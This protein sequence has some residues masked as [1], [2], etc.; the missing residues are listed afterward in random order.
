[1]IS[2]RGFFGLAAAA[3]LAVLAAPKAA[4]KPS[5]LSVAEY[6][7][8]EWHEAFA[9]SASPDLILVDDI[10]YR[11]YKSILA[12]GE[13]RS[14]QTRSLRRMAREGPP[15]VQRRAY[16]KLRDLKKPPT[17][18]LQSSGNVDAVSAPF[19]DRRFIVHDCRPQYFQFSALQNPLEW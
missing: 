9:L 12:K 19:V 3:P 5:T 15:Q 2:R 17:R 13:A 1:M 16:K 8:G 18:Y 11:A 4:A 6:K 10:Y 14:A 7:W